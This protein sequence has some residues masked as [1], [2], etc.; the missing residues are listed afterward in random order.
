MSK[1]LR[2]N[3][4]LDRADNP[5]LYDELARFTKGAKRVNR[6]RTLAHAGLMAQIPAAA[7]TT[8]VAPQPQNGEHDPVH[9]AASMELFAPAIG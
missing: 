5:P 4:E 7:T 1:G 2:I 8:S 3:F 6:L 9:A